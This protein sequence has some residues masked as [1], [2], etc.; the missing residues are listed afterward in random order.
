MHSILCNGKAHVWWKRWE[1]KLASTLDG[2]VHGIG[3]THQHVAKSTKVLIVCESKLRMGDV[4]VRLGYIGAGDDRG[5]EEVRWNVMFSCTFLISGIP[6]PS[7]LDGLIFCFT[8][9]L[10]ISIVIH[11]DHFRVHLQE[12]TPHT[13]VIA[14]GNEAIRGCVTAVIGDEFA[15]S[16][17]S[18]PLMDEGGGGRG[19]FDEDDRGYVLPS[20]CDVG[21]K[22][23][24]EMV[25]DA[26][27][28]HELDEKVEEY[29]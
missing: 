2:F 8:P 7:C 5:S 28:V 12:D 20:V 29:E 9:V 17:S 14:G 18:K 3:C 10:L 11:C 1:V 15:N 23:N 4:G 22:A 13:L 16:A 21:A 25:K 26:A 6:P 24:M 27:L 19:F